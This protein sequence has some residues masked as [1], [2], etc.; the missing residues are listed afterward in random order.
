MPSPDFHYYLRYNQVWVSKRP[1]PY[2]Y[3][4]DVLEA[5]A[6]IEGGL[7]RFEL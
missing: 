7:V 6:L 4:L 5:Y 1:I 2:L 3:P